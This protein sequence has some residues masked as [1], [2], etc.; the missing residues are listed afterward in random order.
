MLI[1]SGVKAPAYTSWE[2]NLVSFEYQRSTFT[3]SRWNIYV[4]FQRFV[5]I[6]F[7]FLTKKGKNFVWNIHSKN[8]S[9]IK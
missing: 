7:E 2:Q 6:V 5:I 3:I 8:K 4:L 1:T 9:E